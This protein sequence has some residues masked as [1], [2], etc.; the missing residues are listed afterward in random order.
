MKKTL[1]WVALAAFIVVAVYLFNKED[2]DEMLSD[3]SGDGSSQI[4]AID[5]P[6]ETTADTVLNT[7]FGKG[8]ELIERY[9]KDAVSSGYVTEFR[10]TKNIGGNLFLETRKGVS[11]AIETYV[12]ETAN[13]ESSSYGVPLIPPTIDPSF[14]KKLE[15]AFLFS[16][17]AGQR[18]EQLGKNVAKFGNDAIVELDTSPYGF[19]L[20]PPSVS[21]IYST[22]ISKYGKCSNFSVLS[23]NPY[24]LAVK[25][26]ASDSKKDKCVRGNWVKLFERELLSVLE[27][28]I[29]ETKRLDKELKSQAIS[30][31]IE[32]GYK[33]TGI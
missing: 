24:T 26:F 16:Q 23:L 4:P 18:I 33:F 12:T 19:R 6:T 25:S 5:P 31:L 11:Q 30:A 27:R 8:A 2:V 10:R 20:T 14:L 13:G 29:S 3:D 22:Y 1:M 32:S 17:N 28:M 9:M 15:S 21:G 7:E